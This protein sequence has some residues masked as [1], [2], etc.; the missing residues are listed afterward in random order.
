MAIERREAPQ[1]GRER[2]REA[3]TVDSI[4]NMIAGNVF[5]A[6]KE[7]RLPDRR[8]FDPATTALAEPDSLTGWTDGTH[9][10]EAPVVSAN[11]SRVNYAMIGVPIPPGIHRVRLSIWPTSV[12]VGMTISV[13]SL[14]VWI[15]L[16]VF[17][18]PRD[19]AIRVSATVP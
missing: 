18:R 14:L 17:Q 7:G 13:A 11:W 15:R 19:R 10:G 5:A 16:A 12:W 9:P 8:L 2:K 1:P 6:I 3:S 4:A